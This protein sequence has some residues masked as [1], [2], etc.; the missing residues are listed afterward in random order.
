MYQTE[1]A[2]EAALVFFLRHV[3]RE[4]LPRNQWHL[5][6]ELAVRKP[7]RISNRSIAA[8]IALVKIQ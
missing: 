5:P 1:K 7:I 2:H 3:I 8:S 4:M 6:S